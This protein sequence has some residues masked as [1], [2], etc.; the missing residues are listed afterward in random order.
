MRVRIL[1]KIYHHTNSPNLSTPYRRK[2]EEYWIRQ[3]CT[4]TP[5]GC[6]DNIS[7]IGNLSSPA[8]ESVNVL[9]LFQTSQ[10]RQRSHGHRHY[11]RPSLKTVNFGTL[12]QI[13]KKSLGLHNV[14]NALYG[15][16][17]S[18]LR[19]LQ[20]EC[21]TNRFNDEYSYEF[22][23]NAIILDI[24]YNR[25]FKPVQTSNNSSELRSF[26]KLKFANKGLDEI[27]L[28]NIL[29]NK[30]SDVRNSKLF[31]GTKCSTDFLFLYWLHC[32]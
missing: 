32:T 26:L 1:E 22:R 3:L 20:A 18:L 2:R 24:A 11:N 5:Y 23:L 31:Q 8:C 7:T 28:T 9:N 29:H 16:P 4:A 25:L 12:L 15:I 19:S 27:N 13:F 6:N 10:R 21:E 14:R 30:K 17:L